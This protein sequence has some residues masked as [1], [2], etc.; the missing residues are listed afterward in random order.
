MHHLEAKFDFEHL[1]ASLK[2][3]NVNFMNPFSDFPHLRQAFSEGE[4]WRVAPARLDPLLIKG[5]IS[6]EAYDR[7]KQNGAV[8]SHMENLQ[9]RNGFKGF[10]QKGVSHIIREVNP[11]SQAL[12]GN[13]GAA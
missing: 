1:R 10:N 12:K 6:Q 9:R 2:N 8:G 13:G 5:R 7:I 3:L 4:I 11:E